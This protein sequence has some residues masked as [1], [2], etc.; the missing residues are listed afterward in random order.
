MSI[1]LEQLRAANEADASRVRRWI[2]V[3]DD[4]LTD[5]VG[6]LS[7]ASAGEVGI[8]LV[9]T[10]WKP[11]QRP[12]HKQK[13]AMVL[14]SQRHFA[15]EQAARGVAVRYVFGEEPYDALLA[16]VVEELGPLEMMEAAAPTG[17]SVWPAA[18][19]G[20]AGAPARRAACE[21]RGQ[22]DAPGHIV[23]QDYVEHVAGF[24]VG[25]RALCGFIESCL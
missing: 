21:G 16:P 14:A 10:S 19:G 3:P 15:L 22:L 18:A 12:Y 6:P 13:L 25:M 7:T 8:V 5:R 17:V 24:A 1:F 9:E 2:Y 11:R 20:G 23:L 4:Q